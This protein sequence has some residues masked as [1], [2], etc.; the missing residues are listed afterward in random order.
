MRMDN[1][2]SPIYDAIDRGQFDKAIV[3]C[4]RKELRKFE[5]TKAL[6]AYAL[7]KTRKHSD[8][9]ALAREVASR[10]PRDSV[11]LSTLSFTLRGLHVEEELTTCYESAF[12]AD[13]SNESL[14]T[15]LFHC[16]TRFHYYK[17]PS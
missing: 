8:A 7:Y 16:Y 4:Q 9:L 13:Q 17:Y 2:F 14:G 12:E 1:I 6:M 3:I 15:D 10:S 5:L 11:V